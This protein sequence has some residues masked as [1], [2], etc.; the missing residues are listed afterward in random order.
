[1][2]LADAGGGPIGN[3]NAP[4]GAVQIRSTAA[5]GTVN[6]NRVVRVDSSGRVGNISS[7][8]TVLFLRAPQLNNV[9]AQGNVGTVRIEQVDNG[10][11][12][13]DFVGVISSAA[14]SV[15]S[16]TTVAAIRG[17]ITADTGSIGLLVS[18]AGIGVPAGTPATI[19]ARNG[20]VQ[21]T[22]PFINAN[23]DAKFNGGNGSISTL[24]ATTG[25]V[26]G[27]LQAASITS[28]GLGINIAGGLTAAV[29]ITG[30]VQSTIYVAGPASSAVTLAGTTSE[31]V[32]FAGGF[33]AGSLTIG[34][35]GSN[36]SINGNLGATASVS[37]VAFGT[38]LSVTGNQSG[39]MT[40]AGPVIGTY[41]VGG[42]LIGSL[43]LPSGGLGGQVIINRNNA[44]GTW[45]GPVM[46]GGP[47]LTPQPAYGMSSMIYGGG[48]VGL[49]PFRLY[50]NDCMPNNYPLA[51]GAI[52][53]GNF[54]G[55]AAV[56][57]R[58]YGPVERADSAAATDALPALVIEQRQPDLMTFIPMNSS[59]TATFQATGPGIFRRQ[60]LIDSATTNPAL[61]PRGVFRIR[62]V[63]T[64][65]TRLVCS[66][67]TGSPV[68]NTADD[69]LGFQ[70]FFQIVEDC[71][72]LTADL[73]G[74]GIVD[75][76]DLA[77]YIT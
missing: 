26:A 64:G 30:N 18:D 46:V 23:I 56:Q 13:V 72:N 40:F 50:N 76:D 22:A 77:D 48:A 47:P 14:G 29:T 44:G 75:P 37:S 71:I 66:G 73:N 41:A 25:S 69:A 58:M 39:S 42:S 8:T 12:P 3:I 21:I 33:P 17:S 9:F 32:T 67:V 7:A 54:A 16:V 28:G 59:F 65:S 63:L 38:T 24:T 1:V 60:I 74:D 62:P 57:L 51:P 31:P 53:V 49:A 35:V 36:F 27:S 43:S 45:T 55:A 6:A 52:M 70:Y 68:V 10:P 15:N 4:D 61:T 11:L 19:R 5:T 20:I 2:Q 34:T